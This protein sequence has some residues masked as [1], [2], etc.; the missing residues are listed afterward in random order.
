MP[1][2]N[3]NI[4]L[5]AKG[6]VV[7]LRPTLTPEMIKYAVINAGVCNFGANDLKSLGDDVAY[8]WDDGYDG[9]ELA[10]SLDDRHGYDVDTAFVDDMECVISNVDNVLKL[11][12]KDW[13]T[14]YSPLPPFEIGSR[15]TLWD[16]NGIITGINEH[17]AATYSVLMDSEP[18]DSTTRRLIK[19]ELAVL[20]EPA[21]K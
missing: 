10:K 4:L 13:V 14:A 18:K 16:G 19:F 3:G 7:P 1:K 2:E 15:L 21:A 11:A 6:K 17:A 12:E 20:E 9:Y 8:C 5:N